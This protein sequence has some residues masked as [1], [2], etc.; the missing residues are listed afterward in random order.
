ME[1][2]N[3]MRLAHTI[4]FTPVSIMGNFCVWCH[5]HLIVCLLLLFYFAKCISC[6]SLH[7]FPC[8]SHWHLNSAGGEEVSIYSLEEVTSDTESGTVSSWSS[9][10]LSAML[11]PLSSE[12]GSLDGGLRRGSRVLCTWAERDVLRPGLVYIVKAFK[13]EVV[14]AWQRYFH[15]ST[16]LQ[17]CLRVSVPNVKCTY[18][19]YFI[20]YLQ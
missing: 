5:S 3:L 2:N 16:A 9:R 19:T 11:Q 17:L 14:R 10:G 6:I 8:S 1:R 13:P 4:P 18:I 20:P 15:G 7:L 12:E